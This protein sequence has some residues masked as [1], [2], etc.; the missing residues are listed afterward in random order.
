M[1]EVTE[2]LKTLPI[3]NSLNLNFNFGSQPKMYATRQYQRMSTKSYLTPT[4][5]S[6]AT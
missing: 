5:P 3:T 4:L 1:P 6:Q 2:K